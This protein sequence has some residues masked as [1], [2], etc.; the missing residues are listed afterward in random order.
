[1]CE[2]A[3]QTLHRPSCWFPET[4]TS[5]QIPDQC[6]H[7]V[8]R[9]GSRSHSPALGGLLPLLLLLLL[10]SLLSFWGYCWSG[11]DGLGAQPPPAQL[12]LHFFCA[13]RRSLHC[14]CYHRPKGATQ[15]RP[16]RPII[17]LCVFFFFFSPS[18]FKSPLPS[19]TSYLYPPGF[20]VCF[21]QCSVSFPN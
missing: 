19:Q 3:L 15:I 10:D 2:A 8:S 18:P 6:V 7:V 4:V 16:S 12:G 11:W 17:N 20:M 21:P 5:A 9:L 13:S 14:V 1:M